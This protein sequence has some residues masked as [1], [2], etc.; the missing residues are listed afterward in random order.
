MIPYKEYSYLYPPRPEKAFSPENLGF[1]ENLGWLAQIKRN[2]DCTMLFARKGELRVMNRHGEVPT[3]WAPSP[4]QIEFFA[5]GDEWFVY[6]AERVGVSLYI[7]DLVVCGGTQLVGTNFNDRQDI[8]YNLFPIY[9]ETE[10]ELHLLNTITIAKCHTSGFSDIFSR[11]GPR[12]EGLVIKD[13]N[14]RLSPCF[15]DKQNGGWQVKARIPTKN[16]SF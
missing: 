13:P 5:R 9:K 11:L 3:R 1:Y 8:L 15:R 6:A 7:F 14:G 2:G 12:D 10:D 16:Y 4:E